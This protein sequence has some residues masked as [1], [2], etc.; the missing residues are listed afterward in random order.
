MEK[1]KVI[2]DHDGGVDDLLSLMLLLTME[3]VELLG[4][5]I[6]PADCFL[7]DATVSTL[8]ILTLFGKES[9]P[10]AQGNIAGENPF[11]YEW[12]AQPKICN[13]LPDMLNIEHN[14][15]QVSRLS[16]DEFIQRTLSEHTGVTLLMTGPCTNLAAALKA[17]PQITHSIDKLVWMGGR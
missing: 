5:T 6:T 15:Q 13:A 4:V 9:I 8:K 17:A 2:F 14:M 3:H 10:V 12:R 1:K 7:S 11:P 16:A